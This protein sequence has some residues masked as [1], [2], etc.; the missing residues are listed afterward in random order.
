MTA[1]GGQATASR[2]LRL[3]LS[4]TWRLIDTGRDYAPGRNAHVDVL[5]LRLT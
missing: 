3:V 2:A 4:Q 5:T 1:S